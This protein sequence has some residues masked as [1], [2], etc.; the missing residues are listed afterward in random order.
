MSDEI[1]ICIC[2]AGVIGLLA[3]FA[4]T[5]F[6]GRDDG[7]LRDRLRGGGKFAATAAVVAQEQKNKVPFKDLIQRLGLLAAAPFMPKTREKQSG[8]RQS[9]ARA[10]IYNPSAFKAMTGGKVISMAVGV[11]VGYGIGSWQDSTFLGLA[12]GGLIGYMAPAMWLKSKIS[13]NQQALTHGLADALD[14]MVVCVEAGL[15]VDAA[16]QRV[17]VDLALAHPSLARELNIAHMETRV[18]LSR[19]ESLKNL[20]SRTGNPALISL[21]SM[22]IQADRFGTS[23][24]QALRVHADTLR[25]NRQFAAEESASKAAVKLTFP[26]VLFIFPATFIVLAG[27]TAVQ[28]MNSDLMK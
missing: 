12:L 16:M 23:I 2:I 25:T 17:G 7:K 8:L 27:P 11:G 26:L 13:A 1:L 5:F 15:T 3:Y 14:L 22:L 18:G 6:A 19:A 24:A 21:A 20:G 4:T 10:G 9:L 28:V